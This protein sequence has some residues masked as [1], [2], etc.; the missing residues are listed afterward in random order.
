MPTL[1]LKELNSE[2]YAENELEKE[3]VMEEAWQHYQEYL[4]SEEVREQIAEEWRPKEPAVFRP[5]PRIRLLHEARNKYLIQTPYWSDHPTSVGTSLC[6]V[7]GLNM[8]RI[9]R[10]HDPENPIK[11]VSHFDREDGC[12]VVTV[13]T[14]K[15]DHHT[16]F[17][18]E[19]G[20]LELRSGN[21]GLLNCP[22]AAELA[23]ELPFSP[24]YDLFFKDDHDLYRWFYKTRQSAIET[25]GP[26]VPGIHLEIIARKASHYCD[27]EDS[28]GKLGRLAKQ[29]YWWTGNNAEAI[30][31]TVLKLCYEVADKERWRF[32]SREVKAGC[33]AWNEFYTM[34]TPAF[35]FFKHSEFW[36]HFYRSQNDASK[37]EVIEAFA[38]GDKPHEAFSLNKWLIKYLYKTG[39]LRALYHRMGGDDRLSRIIRALNNMSPDNARKVIKVITKWSMSLENGNHFVR[40]IDNIG[41]LD[42]ALEHPDFVRAL[43]NDHNLEKWCKCTPRRYTTLE[44]IINGIGDM[45]HG[46]VTADSLS[47]LGRRI[48]EWNTDQGNRIESTLLELGRDKYEPYKLPLFY[49]YESRNGGAHLKL[50]RLICA[51]DLI[52]EGK[53]QSHCIAM[54]DRNGNK[55]GY[56]TVVYSNPEQDSYDRASLQLV[57]TL[58]GNYAV[59]QLYQ[60]HNREVSPACRKAVE[61]ALQVLSQKG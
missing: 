41:G 30:K 23:D 25:G 57:I 51:A 60:S 18:P 56:Y 22:H 14:I 8:S 45:E 40:P 58:Q 52:A 4:L 33:D 47:A 19:R 28:R 20:F 16:V 15:R 27:Y 7:P 11:M 49:S 35:L 10:V 26:L 9:G 42:L 2:Y 17:H 55:Y 6:S 61:E 48:H 5:A 50:E 44:S 29:W 53:K 59:G 54:H 43:V 31:R 1:T 21:Q 3:A 12:R 32:A 36:L 39:Y 38:N 37:K 13:T 46:V 24:D 34:P